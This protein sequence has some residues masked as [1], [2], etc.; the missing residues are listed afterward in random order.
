[1]NLIVECY[2][3]DNKISSGYLKEI[4]IAQAHY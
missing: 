2:A 3:L 1:M 4:E